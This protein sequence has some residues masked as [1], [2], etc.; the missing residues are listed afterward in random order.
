[1]FPFCRDVM[2]YSEENSVGKE[3]KGTVFPPHPVALLLSSPAFSAV[4]S[5]A[6]RILRT[7]PAPII[8]WCILNDAHLSPDLY[9]LETKTLPCICMH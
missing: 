4:I 5:P 1:M 2:G 6:V 9:D 7:Q 3:G 8:R